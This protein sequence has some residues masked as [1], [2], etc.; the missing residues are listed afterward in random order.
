MPSTRISLNYYRSCVASAIIEGEDL[1]SNHLQVILAVLHGET[2]G[3]ILA[4]L[5]FGSKIEFTIPKNI[6]GYK[7]ILL[8][9]RP[10]G[11]RKRSRDTQIAKDF[12]ELRKTISS[13]EAYILLSAESIQRYGIGLG[14]DR[15]KA[16]V[17]KGRKYE[18]EDHE[19]FIRACIA[20]G[21][22]P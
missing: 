7:P 20:F 10:K 5:L 18:K 15:V 11:D 4:E 8:G 3:K 2:D 17:T 6:K 16:C 13:E 14:V 1:S 22:T 12:E 19:N 9:E 21:D